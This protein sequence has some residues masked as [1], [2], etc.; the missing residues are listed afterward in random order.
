MR[1][2]LSSIGAQASQK[3]QDVGY[4]RLP[5]S[6]TEPLS[7]LDPSS[8]T[9]QHAT[10]EMT[11]ISSHSEHQQDDKPEKKGYSV[12]YAAVSTREVDTGALVGE[13]EVF[14][15]DAEALRIRYAIAYYIQILI[16][17]TEHSRKKIDRHILPLMMALYW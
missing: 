5:T 9:S 3:R 17:L 13:E 11:S 15:D 14:L 10:L 16:R 1:R 6:V 4:K 8:S 12:H 7:A 2:F